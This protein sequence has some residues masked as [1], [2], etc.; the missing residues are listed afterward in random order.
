MSGDQWGTSGFSIYWY[1]AY[2]QNVQC[3][4]Q[5]V[6]LGHYWGHSSINRKGEAQLLIEVLGISTS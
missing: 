3:L 6:A 2:S 4:S 1:L 5:Y